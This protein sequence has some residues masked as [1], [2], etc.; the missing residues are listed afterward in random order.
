MKDCRII[1]NLDSP[2]STIL[3]TPNATD[4]NNIKIVL[5]IYYYPLQQTDNVAELSDPSKRHVDKEKLKIYRI[6]AE[7]IGPSDSSAK[8]SNDTPKYD[9]V[10]F[11]EKKISEVQEVV[12]SSLDAKY[13]RSNAKLL[14]ENG[15][16]EDDDELNSDYDGAEVELQQDAENFHR[17]PNQIRMSMSTKVYKQEF[18]KSYVP[19]EAYKE[20]YNQ[21]YMPT[22][23]YKER[24]NQGHVLANTYNDR[25]NNKRTFADYHDDEIANHAL[26]STTYNSLVLREFQ[27]FLNTH[28]SGFGKYRKPAFKPE[29]T[30]SNYLPR[31]EKVGNNSHV[32]II[33]NT[34]EETII[35]EGPIEIDIKTDPS[36]R[37]V[38]FRFQPG[39]GPN[40]SLKIERKSLVFPQ[41]VYKKGKKNKLKLPSANNPI[42]VILAKDGSRDAERSMQVDNDN[43]T[44][45]LSFSHNKVLEKDNVLEMSNPLLKFVDNPYNFAPW[46]PNPMPRDN[47]F[48]FVEKPVKN[49]DSGN[50]VFYVG[51]E[52]QRPQNSDSYFVQALR[53][54]PIALSLIMIFVIVIVVLLL[55]A[56]CILGRRPKSYSYS[57]VDGCDHPGDG[58]E[59]S[60]IQKRWHYEF[61]KGPFAGCRGTNSQVKSPLNHEDSEEGLDCGKGKTINIADESGRK[62]TKGNRQHTTEKHDESEDRKELLQFF[63]RSNRKTN[64]MSPGKRHRRGDIE[65]N[66]I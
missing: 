42:N 47:N 50:G 33:N 2:D 6:T 43:Q 16:Q 8:A 3:Y 49:A 14:Y 46:K 7:H 18:T 35:E 13:R 51:D 20:Y 30:T 64:S 55:Y 23:V 26:R 61:F 66:T 29:P 9:A 32:R 10:E 54:N 22:K 11:E 62:E 15:D 53:S 44:L 5:I 48:V 57:K 19:P 28:G 60:T 21:N 37:K 36:T 1:R 63:D 4:L 31:T 25:D 24:D 34:G 17:M 56:V 12:T 45:M 39:Q 38:N 65:M 58:P 40:I 59:V 52:T 27:K 41:D